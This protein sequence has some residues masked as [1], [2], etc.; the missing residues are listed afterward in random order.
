MKTTAT[1]ALLFGVGALVLS[2]C[3][4]GTAPEA[5]SPNVT[6]ATST[7]NE[8][9]TTT[10]VPEPGQLDFTA[11]HTDLFDARAELDAA[12][13]RWELAA[14]DDY[15]IQVTQSC[16]CDGWAIES[17]VLR[18]EEVSS[19]FLRSPASDAGDTRPSTVDDL[20]ARSERLLTELEADP[21][22]AAA[23]ECDG[24]HLDLTFDPDNGVPTLSSD[25]TPCDGGAAWITRFTEIDPEGDD[26]LVDLNDYTEVDLRDLGDPE[27]MTFPGHDGVVVVFAEGFDTVE[28]VTR[29]TFGRPCVNAVDEAACQREVDELLSD[30]IGVALVELNQCGM[31]LPAHLAMVATS[32]SRVELVDAESLRSLIGPIDTPT[33]ALITTGMSGWARPLDGGG[34]ETVTT[35]LVADCDPIIQRF[36]VANVDERGFRGETARWFDV[37]WGTCI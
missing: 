6:T 26:P 12:R 10:E 29:S 8:A 3:G 23:T 25:N 9:T 2:A 13:E 11:D 4:P 35:E 27:A 16:E 37:E 32:G 19:R 5:G 17:I 1:L 22:K 21:S 31:C 36:S 28:S 14:I 20:F 18:G 33:E 34:F 30:P 15:A 24:S 7:P